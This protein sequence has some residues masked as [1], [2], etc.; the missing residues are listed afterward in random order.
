MSRI[1]DDVADL[2]WAEKKVRRAKVRLAQAQKE[3]ADETETHAKNNHATWLAHNLY[4]YAPDCDHVVDARGITIKN[5]HVTYACAGVEMTYARQQTHYLDDSDLFTS[6]TI[7]V[8]GVVVM[9]VCHDNLV[10]P[11]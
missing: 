2:T 1:M 4:K 8:D 3:L 5:G 9:Q 11:T 10:I 7:T 6:S